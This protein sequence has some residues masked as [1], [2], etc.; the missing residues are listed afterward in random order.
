VKSY[1]N[2]INRLSYKISKQQEAVMEKARVFE[3]PSTKLQR[4]K[5]KLT[6]EYKLW[7]LKKSN[8]P[9]RFHDVERD[10]NF[11]K[12]LLNK[13]DYTAT[14]KSNIDRLCEKYS[15]K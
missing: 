4:L 3:S 2:I 9:N 8:Y 6:E 12:S 11:V 1:R 10:V 13:E 15:I 5:E 14:E 7:S